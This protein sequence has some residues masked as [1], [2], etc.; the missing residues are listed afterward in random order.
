MLDEIIKNKLV[1]KI[2][3]KPRT[4]TDSLDNGSERKKMA[5]APRQT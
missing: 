1:T 3:K 4:R 2:H 5:C